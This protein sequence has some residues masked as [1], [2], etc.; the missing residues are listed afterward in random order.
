MTEF[1]C[2]VPA[3][4]IFKYNDNTIVFI[5]SGTDYEEFLSQFE[6]LYFL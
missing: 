5:A 2:F 3:R 4:A 6:G 1:L